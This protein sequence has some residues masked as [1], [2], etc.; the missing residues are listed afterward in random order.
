MRRY[1]AKG[2]VIIKSLG[3]TCQLLSYTRKTYPPC[4]NATVKELQSGNGQISGLYLILA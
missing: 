4:A 1:L 2:T 3:T